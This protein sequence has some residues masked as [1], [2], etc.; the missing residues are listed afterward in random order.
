LDRST[1]IYLDVVRPFAAILV[2]LSHVNDI[3]LT[4]GRLVFF[5]P[6]GVQAVDMFFVLSGFVI[7][8]VC[9]TRERD[10]RSYFISR[11]A[12]IYSVAI[13]ALVLGAVADAIGTRNDATIYQAS[14]QPLSFGLLTRSI[15]F[16]GEMWDKHRFPGSNGAY[17]SLGFEVWYYIAFGVFLFAPRKWRYIATTLVL[18]FIGPKVSLLFPLWLMGVFVYR[19][20][21]KHRL[22]KQ[23]GWAFLIVPLL[24]AAAYQFFPQQP[25][26]AFINIT[27][28]WER[29]RSAGQDYLIA[30]LFSLHLIGFSAV[31]DVFSAW[32]DRHAA[33]IRWISGATF[34]IYLV[35]LPIMHMLATISPWPKSSVRNLIFLLTLTPCACLLFAEMTERRKNVWKQ[36]F[37]KGLCAVEGCIQKAWAEDETN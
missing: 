13:P 22:S 31:S 35:H 33:L 2:L 23:M 37:T 15:F 1:S 21:E 32:L 10:P 29:F 24:L 17:W 12:R 27:P 4:E 11:A 20:N 25:L 30:A 26:Q 28:T 14:Y 34:S 8:S 36:L 18:L 5:D 3:G 19:F 6:F 7:A 16:I 9:A